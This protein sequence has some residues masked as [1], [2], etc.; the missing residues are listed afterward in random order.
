MD[1][2]AIHG[3]VPPKIADLVMFTL[4]EGNIAVCR[5]EPDTPACAAAIITPVYALDS[6]GPAAVPTGRIFIR[7][8]EHV[9]VQSRQQ[10][11]ARAGYEIA[12]SIPYAPH[13]AWLQASGAGMAEALNR[14]SALEAIM[15]VKNIEPQMLLQRKSK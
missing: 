15:G 4:N 11:L 5:G 12:E 10:E 7:F 2:Y 9:D 8:L 1:C 3:E 13:A 14:L 6:Q